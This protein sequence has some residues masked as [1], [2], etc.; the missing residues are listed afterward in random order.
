RN[1]LL[2]VTLDKKSDGALKYKKNYFTE[3]TQ[4][5][6][7]SD[8]HISSAPI[9]TPKQEQ[10]ASET[11]GTQTFAIQFVNEDKQKTRMAPLPENRITFPNPQ[12]AMT[13]PRPERVRPGEQAPTVVKPLPSDAERARPAP[14]HA[15]KIAL[16]INTVPASA[17]VIVDDRYLGQSPLI[18]YIDRYTDHLIQISKQGYEE[19]AKFIDHHEF[20]D[21][22]IFFL[23]EKLEAKN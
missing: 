3:M 11:S 2:T 23:I 6:S 10:V 13:S 21:Q 1:T 17:D 15:G 12:Q 22:K 18:T 4:P 9:T 8:T 20:G 14:E 7:S 16:Q 5:H 19:K